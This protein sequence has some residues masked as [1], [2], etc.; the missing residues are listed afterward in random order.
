M[1][2]IPAREFSIH[3]SRSRR[4]LAQPRFLLAMTAMV[5]VVG[6]V[7]YLAKAQT[8]RAPVKMTPAS[9]ATGASGLKTLA[10]LPAMVEAYGKSRLLAKSATASG[11]RTASAIGSGQS[12][13]NLV[14][15]DLTP[16]SFSDDREPIYSPGGDFIAFAS[17]GKDSNKDG[18]IDSDGL[19]AERK[20]HIWVMGRDGS[21]QRQ[22]SGLFDDKARN[23]RRPSWAPDAKQLVYVDGDG[24]NSELYVAEPFMDTDFGT[25]GIQVNRASR[26]TFFNPN[27]GVTLRSPAW[28]PSGQTIVFAADA[29]LDN[30]T[31]VVGKPFNLFSITPQ[32]QSIVRLTGGRRDITAGASITMPVNDLN[33][34]FS[35]INSNVLYFSSNRTN[36]SVI[37]SRRIWRI[38][39]DGTSKVQVT[40][41]LQRSNG[42]V[43]DSDDFPSSSLAGAMEERLAFQTNSSID[44]SDV[45][46]S[47]ARDLNIWSLP[48][49]SDIQVPFVESEPRVFAANFNGNRVEILN[50]LNGNPSDS[51]Q[52]IDSFVMN[53]EGVLVQDKFVYVASRGTNQLLRFDQETSV[54]NP[55][56]FQGGIGFT[57]DNSVPSPTD[58]IS[59][60]FYFYVGSGNSVSG[61]ANQTAIYRFGPSGSS[62]GAVSGKPSAAFSN[63]E[64]AAD[65]IQNGSEGLTFSPDSEQTYIFVSSVSD[66][67]VNVYLRS[68]G[69]FVRTFVAP[70][71]GG[72]KIPTGLTFGP[73]LNRDGFKDLYVNSSATDSVL[74]YAG[75]DPADQGTDVNDPTDDLAAKVGPNRGLNPGT[76]IKAVI[77]DVNG[78]K[79]NLNA[80]EGIRIIRRD[81]GKVQ[82]FVSS[83]RNATD[84]GAGIA[85]ATGDHINR[86][87]LDPNTLVGVSAPA[88]FI[89]K[90]PDIKQ[91]ATY[92]VFNPNGDGVGGLGYFD[93]NQLARD[94][95]A[96]QTGR[97]KPTPT[98]P[99]T[100]GAL[101]TKNTGIRA[102]QVNTNIL[103]SPNNYAQ[104]GIAPKDGSKDNVGQD[105]APDIEPA[106]A[107][108]ESTP[109][110][111]SQLA[112]ASTRRFSP[113]PSSNV[114]D[115]NGNKPG[116]SNPFGEGAQ[117][118]SDIWSTSSEDTTPP[119]LIPQASGNQ[120]FPVVAPG[121]Q[122]PF[123]APRTAETGLRAGG[124]VTV[125]VVLRDLESGL[126][127]NFGVFANFYRAGAEKFTPFTSKV[128]EGVSVSVRREERPPV[129]RSVTLQTF[130]D[131]PPSQGGHERQAGAISGDGIYYCVGTTTTS[132]TAGDF[133][134]DILA[135]DRGGNFFPYDNIWGFSTKTFVK[136]STTSNFFVSD[137]TA[138][139][140]FPAQLGNNDFVQDTRFI[141]ESPVESYFL[142]NNG[143]QASEG[144]AAGLSVATT[145]S[146]VDVWR[147]LSRGP[148]PST[149]IDAYRPRTT[150]QINPDPTKDPTF[151]QKNRNVAVADSYIIWAAPYA[152]NSFVGPGT[153]TDATTQGNLTNFLEAG[154]RLFVTG[155]DVAFALSNDSTSTNDFLGNELGA[156]FQDEVSTNNIDLVGG[157][158]NGFIRFPKTYPSTYYNLQI[159]DRPNIKANENDLYTDGA[160]TQQPLAVKGIGVKM[161]TIT[162]SGPG[163]TPVYAIGGATVGQKVARTRDNGLQSRVVFFSF[164]LEGVNR[165][166]RKAI[167]DFP[168]VALDTR[169]RIADGLG[170]Y[171]KTNT[172]KGS[173]IND[174]TNL[175]IANFLVRITSTGTGGGQIYLA[176][177]DANGN[178]DLTGIPQGTYTAEPA[179]LLDGK[180]VSRTTAGAQTS[181]AGF[182]GGT[183]AQVTAVLNNGGQTN[184]IGDGITGQA[185]LRPIPITPGTISGRIVTSKGTPKFSDDLPINQKSVDMAVLL[186]SVENTSSTQNGG[187]Y[188]QLVR[189]NFNGNFTFSKVPAGIQLEV[190]FNPRVDNP[191]TTNVDEGDIPKESGLRAGYGGP[192]TDVGRRLIP[193]VRHAQLVVAPVGNTFFLNDPDPVKFPDPSTG[194]AAGSADADKAADSGVPLVIPEGA[195]LSGIVKLNG[196][197]FENAKVELFAVNGTALVSQQIRTTSATGA[198]TFGDLLAGKYVVRA[199]AKLSDGTEV[200]RS[201]PQLTLGTKDLTYNFD[202]FLAKVSGLA[203][204][205]GKPQAN[206]LIQLL[207]SAGKPIVR[208]GSDGKTFTLVRTAQTD[209]GQTVNYVL[210]NVPAGQYTVRASLGGATGSA[211][212]TVGTSQNLVVPTIDL[213]PQKLSGVVALR[214]DG[215]SQGGLS[216]V[217][218]ELLDGSGNPLAPPVTTV[219]GSQGAYNFQFIS[220]GTYKV[221]A[222]FKGVTVTSAAFTLNNGNDPKPTLT[223]DLQTVTVTV[224]NPQGQ[225]QSAVNVTLSQSGNTVKTGVTNASGQFKFVDVPAGTYDVSATKDDLSQSASNVIVTQG[226]AT[227]L[228]LKLVIAGSGSKVFAAN[229][230]YPFSLPLA[231]DGTGLTIDEAFNLPLSSNAYKIYFFDAAHQ[232]NKP[233]TEFDFKEYRSGSTRLIRGRGYVLQTFDQQISTRTVMQNTALKVL[234]SNSL[235]IPLTWNSQFLSDTPE[236][237]NRNNGFNMI[238]F[239]FDPA[240]FRTVSLSEVQV[241]Y[242]TTVFESLSAASAAGIIAQEL[243]TLDENGVRVLNT[244]LTL[245]PYVGY[246]VRILRNDKPITLTLR[247]PR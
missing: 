227:A 244:T 16:N 235:E 220:A 85:G 27:R 237:D 51:S 31:G 205:N 238:G 132:A 161:D 112:F 56:P 240:R 55:S 181:P 29:N 147:T 186:R 158:E 94:S 97:P 20:Y 216:G 120:L 225:P 133:Y 122:S 195:T 93:F 124:N 8:G 50:P 222:T 88:P 151:T 62:A 144:G 39:A 33:P 125:A 185:N 197:A 162:S 22:V 184:L 7:S 10:D 209:S 157:N 114:A 96:S 116:P 53:P 118:T 231:T 191:A 75:P 76:F 92:L 179:F 196:A 3:F 49:S 25:D 83:F 52:G 247:N 149:V 150:Q 230:I 232:V 176:R 106:F 57:A 60:G 47:G 242:G 110:L 137:Y 115:A 219:S 169:K 172:V 145:F 14:E 108:N 54:I 148:V 208:T 221:R 2:F 129:D 91:D 199:T 142:T 35:A 243:Y 170:R 193:D 121:P 42:N 155:R 117:N 187:R 21:K 171:F 13:F 213:V 107:R 198:Y 154:G 67:K 84:D 202:L 182:F 72:L 86:Y 153:I 105:K 159:A 143:G 113:M 177:T 102:A 1:N 183:S 168:L 188:A 146:G 71:A 138:G 141:N 98:P 17:N 246:F 203:T 206:I 207:N 36:A 233:T 95:L 136:Q 66:S 15:T 30:A 12:G 73:D 152:A 44:S 19:N 127:P 40:D 178:Y 194:P 180:L 210:N 101:E 34:A 134:I 23:Q 226:K 28:S 68:T 79:S 9:S 164:G 200:I 70:G 245:R 46:P 78:T 43:N 87:F 128:N 212:I 100:T 189:T 167:P 58:L 74:V 174:T 241:K 165:R 131:G 6:G 156:T 224:L 166:Y 217:T 38:F 59:D 11:G 41:P 109:Q 103:S 175:P 45:A 119:I 229:G 160:L 139:Q 173:V 64:A 228:S 18:R 63:G 111:S 80:P 61:A 215:Q 5:A 190:I 4:A 104:S 163:V 239:P 130:D 48:L 204:L 201:S 126:N 234:D 99:P 192:K 32:G 82:I 223:I 218:V 69:K 140:E 135:F 236:P 77:S 123:P 24:T 65:K 90:N 81:D 26:R 214:V 211:A 89:T 37:G